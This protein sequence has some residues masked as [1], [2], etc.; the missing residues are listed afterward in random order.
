MAR[1]VWVADQRGDAVIKL[2]A[3]GREIGRTGNFERS[4]D[5]VLDPDGG[6]TE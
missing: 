2:T 3:E 4:L 6:T 5:I 1:G